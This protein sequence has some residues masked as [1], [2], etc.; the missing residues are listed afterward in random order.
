MTY[1]PRSNRYNGGQARPYRAAG[2]KPATE[3]QINLIKKLATEQGTAQPTDAQIAAWTTKKASEVISWFFENA[4]K[5]PK[6]ELTQP[7]Y[8]NLTHNTHYA[9]PT[10]D[11]KPR[12]FKVQKPK[13]GRWV[14]YTFVNGEDGERFDRDTSTAILKELNDNWA[15]AL[16]L[17]GHATGKCGYCR[18]ALELKESVERGYGPVCAKNLGLPYD[19]SNVW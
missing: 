18:R 10:P 6:K 5:L 16:S 9:L 12:K 2:P 11:G 13:K 19:P 17:Y 8:E 7:V 14:G 15:G 3:R 4:K 1:Y